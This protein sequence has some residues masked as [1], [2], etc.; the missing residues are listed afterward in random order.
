MTEGL[1]LGVPAELVE[2]IAVRVS[3]LLSERLPAPYEPYL[4]VDEAAEHLAAKKSRIYALVES[5]RLRAYRDGRRLLFRRE[6][7]D[8]ALTIEEPLA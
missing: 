6:D 2:A 1:A 8:A 5:G 4:N 7:L 3:D